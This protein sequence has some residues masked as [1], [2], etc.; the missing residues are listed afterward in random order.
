MVLKPQGLC[1]FW[2]Y[3]EEEVIRGAIFE[4]AGLKINTDDDDDDDE[5][6]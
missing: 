4:L 1:F 6:N 3:G 2:G 5:A